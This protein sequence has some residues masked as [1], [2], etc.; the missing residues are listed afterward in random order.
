MEINYGKKEINKAK[1]R[2]REQN[3]LPNNLDLAATLLICIWEMPGSN[4]G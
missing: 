4:L 2:K 1:Q 3:C